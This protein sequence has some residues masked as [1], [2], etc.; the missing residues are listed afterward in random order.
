MT[1]DLRWWDETE[2]KKHESVFAAVR[3]IQRAQSHRRMND[4]LHL[5]L[6]GNA[7]ATGFTPYSGARTAGRQHT[8]LSLNV[9]KNMIGA[10]VSKIAA[11]NKVKASFQTVG[12][13]FEQQERAEKMER[14]SQGVFY[15]NRLYKK[16]RAVFRDCCISGTG[17][18][19]IF[20][21]EK[22]RAVSHE[23]TPW[24][25]VHVDDADGF[26]GEPRVMYQE[27]WYDRAVLAALFPDKKDAIEKSASVPI[28]EEGVVD[29]ESK[30]R[31]SLVPVVEG[32]HLPSGA[33][34]DDGRRIICIREVDLLDVEYKF[35]YHPFCTMRWSEDPMGYFGTGLAYELAGI[36]VEINELLLEIQRAH[37]LIKGHWLVQD[38]SNVNFR[39][40][41]NDLA[42]IV[43]YAGVAPQYH[44]PTAIAPDV[45]Q[46]LW[47]LYEK[48]YEISGVSQMSATSQK[49]PGI[50]AAVAI[51]A[52]NDIQTE[53]FLEV[54]T[55]LEDWTME[56]AEHTV[57]AARELA[58]AGTFK[59]TG[60]GNGELELI[61]FKDAD[62]EKD[63]YVIQVFPTSLLPSTPAGKLQFVTDMVNSQT[64][65]IDPEDAFE[66][67]QLPDTE[68]MAKRKLAP[69][70]LVERNLSQ[71]VRHGKW[72][73]PEPLDPHE[74]ALR[75]ANETL[76]SARLDNVPPARLELIRKYITLTQ[77]L[78]LQQ[79]P[80]PPPPPPPQEGAMPP[81]GSGGPPPTDM[82]APPEGMPA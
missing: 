30:S 62:M 73:A 49:T 22:G 36:Q 41:N 44:A 1:L 4:I 38:G 28:T 71:I 39:H 68:S 19:K 48:A 37:R 7:P 67:L 56:V 77:R 76:A 50:T 72:V 55:M 29:S 9:V 81:M 23:R 60:R 26:N 16:Q 58:K 80:P 79:N 63:S 21:D 59:V 75:I 15:N 40:I 61:D 5:S 64:P 45:Y 31:T 18:L 25:E 3:E 34:A 82:G 14:F 69:R 53:R 74:V 32:W 52:V 42:S 11:K 46:H 65:L 43:R 6:Y 57:D 8:R 70:K 51:D 12:G 35:P 2:G 20:P 78:L 10:V 17:F 24:W 54:G 13:D 47:N 33:D 27:K 66:L